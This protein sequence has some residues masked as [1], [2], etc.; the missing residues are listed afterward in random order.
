[1]TPSADALEP[2][3][4]ACRR[5]CRRSGSN[6]TAW[7]F[8]LPREKRRAMDA[9]YAFMRHTDDL[10][11]EPHPDHLRAQSLVEWR[12]ALD[13]A[14]TGHFEPPPAVPH[15]ASQP[16]PGRAIL[17]A[18]ADVVRRFRV[19]PESLR[20]VIDGVAMDLHQRRYE[21]FAELEQYCRLVAAAVGEAC[22]HV[23]GFRGP[24]ALVPARQCGI[25]MQ[26]TNI[27]RDLREDAEQDRVY[28]PQEDLRKCEYTIEDLRA[29]RAD[30]RFARLVALEAGRAEALYDQAAALL[31]CLTPDGRRVFGM[32]TAV[33]RALL[34][35]L[36]R[37]PA[38]ILRRR[39]SVGR[40]RKLLIAARWLLGPV[41][42]AP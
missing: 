23:W 3:H 24:E 4:A 10:A 37:R 26:L 21:T 19:P 5:L 8:V 15:A 7:F 33:Y 34:R 22:I 42:G 32:L 35:K 18:V 6:F 40:G 41:G 2:S 9:L 27:L 25:A 16:S 11:D 13:R 20:A 36:A 31:P 14:L 17:P 12:A 30:A 39:V 38:T 28:L 29:G 1:M